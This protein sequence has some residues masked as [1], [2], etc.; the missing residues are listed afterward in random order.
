MPCC[1]LTPSG[2]RTRGSTLGC[3]WLPPYLQNPWVTG[4]MRTGGP[5]G[6]MFLVYGQPDARS[7]AWVGLEQWSGHCVYVHS[8]SLYLC[9]RMF[10]GLNS[11]SHGHTSNRFTAA[12]LGSPSTHPMI[13]KIHPLA[14]P[15]FISGKNKNISPKQMHGHS[16]SGSLPFVFFHLTC[17]LLYRPFIFLKYN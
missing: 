7:S 17:I 3:D 12:A 11:W 6:T 4:G 14:Q 13:E 5:P 8:I 2:E 16:P 10:I 9:K 1:P 15:C